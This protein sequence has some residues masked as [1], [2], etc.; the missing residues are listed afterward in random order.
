MYTFIRNFVKFY[1]FFQ[2]KRNCLG[3]FPKAIP[4][5]DYSS[6]PQVSFGNGGKG[7]ASLLGS[8]H[9]L[10]GGEGNTVGLSQPQSQSQHGL[11]GGHGGTGGHGLGQGWQGFLC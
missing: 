2:Y 9:G 10:G 7:L 1:N 11:T 8:G 6:H 3:F 5:S 4:F